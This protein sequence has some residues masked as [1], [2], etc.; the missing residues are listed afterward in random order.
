[1]FGIFPDTGEPA[2]IANH[3][4]R[5]MAVL[6][7]VPLGASYFDRPANP[8]NRLLIGLCAQAGVTPPATFVA[9]QG[10]TP[11]IRVHQLG[12]ERVVYVLNPGEQP[13]AGELILP[14]PGAAG[15]ATELLSGDSVACRR[16][17]S[18]L[19][20]PV[21]LAASGVQVLHVTP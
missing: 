12:N 7:A 2:L 11:M 19:H 5:G 20:I 21:R 3:M 13:L 14:A 17:G 18:V 16:D 8:V 9:V 6:S 10:V 1:V 4:G 15:H